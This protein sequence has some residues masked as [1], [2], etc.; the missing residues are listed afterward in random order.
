MK[1]LSGLTAKKLL[2]ILLV[3]AGTLCAV[4]LL[5]QYINLELL[6]EKFGP[7]FELTNRFDLDDEVSVPTWISQIYYLLLST[8]AFLASKFAV[9]KAQTRLWITIALIALFGSLDEGA[10][11]HELALQSVHN[12]YFVDQAPSIFANA[13]WVVLPLISI[14]FLLLLMQVKKQF[15][16]TTLILFTFSS[17]VF[18]TG[19]VIVDLLTTSTAGGFLVQGV[20]VAIE[21]GF[22]LIGL[23]VAI[24]AVIRHIETYHPKELSRLKASFKAQ[25]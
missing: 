10:G 21:E 22:E 18:I 16:N 1:R 8:A 9:K 12:V 6:D 5:L 24:Y 20:M 15:D 4:H 17:L 25:A 19:A 3:C 2:V 23:S 14:G 11:L 7:F 13:W